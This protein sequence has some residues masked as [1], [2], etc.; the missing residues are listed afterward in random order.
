MN[1]REKQA[2]KALRVEIGIFL[3]RRG[4]SEATDDYELIS[5][6]P[7]PANEE[8][9]NLLLDGKCTFMAVFNERADG[10]AS[11]RGLGTTRRCVDRIAN[12]QGYETDDCAVY[13][14]D[15]RTYPWTVTL[16]DE[17]PPRE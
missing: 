14:V 1:A 3:G 12:R 13:L 15:P 11:Y 9:C 8:V 10:T 7:F 6:D 5:G 4:K 16:I 2:G 17:V